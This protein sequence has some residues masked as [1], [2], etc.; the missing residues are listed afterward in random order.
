MRGAVTCS[1]HP[2]EQSGDA[3]A[4]CVGQH[5]DGVDGRIRAS[6]LDAGHVGPGEAAPISEGFLAHAHSHTKLPDPG[7]ELVLKRWGGGW[8]GHS[9]MVQRCDLI[10][11]TL[12]VTLA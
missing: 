6:R 9:P 11:H 8:C 10:G 5:L 3:H 2:F 1:S 12:I 7:A 4:Q